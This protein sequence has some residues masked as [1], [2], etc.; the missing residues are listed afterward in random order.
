MPASRVSRFGVRLRALREAANLSQEELADRAGMSVSGLSALERGVRSRP[1]A[2]TLRILREALELDETRWMDLLH[3]AGQTVGVASVEGEQSSTMGVSLTSFV[4]RDEELDWIG[5]L[6]EEHRLVT[7]VGM[8]GIG[9]SRLAGEVL[10]RY[11]S[12]FPGG[13]WGVRLDDLD[14]GAFVVRTVVGALRLREPPDGELEVALEAFLRD[15]RALLVLDGCEP[16]LEACAVLASRLLSACPR[17]AVMATSQASLA[18]PGEALVPLHPLGVPDEAD[19]SPDLRAHA[20]TRLFVERVRLVAPDFDANDEVLPVAELC[21]RLD[22]IPLAIELAAARARLLSPAEIVRR[23]EQG[24]RVLES[25]HM[26]SERHRSLQAALEWSHELLG[27]DEQ[28]LLRRLAVFGGGFTIEAL[29]QVC[30]DGLR[31]DPLLVADELLDRSLVATDRQRRLRLV[32][33]VRRFA[34]DRLVESGEESVIRARHAAAFLEFAEQAEPRMRGPHADEWVQQFELERENLR[35]ALDW[36]VTHGDEGG[37]VRLVAAIAPFWRV[38]GG[39]LPPTLVEIVMRAGAS[40]PGC[41][42]LEGVAFLAGQ[43]GDADTVDR[44]ARRYLD[45]ARALGDDSHV[46]MA[47][48]M[49]QDSELVGL[50]AFDEIVALAYSGNDRWRRAATLCCVQAPDDAHPRHRRCLQEAV[51]EAEAVGDPWL[52][53][54]TSHVFALEELGSGHL[55][56]GRRLLARAAELVDGER[57]PWA[58]FLMLVAL[59]QL[60]LAEQDAGRAVQML[61]AASAIG[62]RTGM[63]LRLASGGEGGELVA[64]ARAEL[65]AN[66]AEAAWRAGTALPYSIALA[67]GLRAQRG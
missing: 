5:H 61:A 36:S 22:G 15:R 41:R 28:M 44:V 47:M 64:R 45:V 8:A 6:L 65:A 43:R 62:E 1:H 38:R 46:A 4:G 67:N 37:V 63:S 53:G 42:A 14:A 54:A 21:R 29:E 16:V 20:A 7:L 10:A 32:D 34:L 23:L 60:A 57:D 48:W 18:L 25:R 49:L 40:A 66:E 17:L 13:A 19:T 58:G 35:S 39:R 3:A 31:A 24:A 26:T 30:C 52:I 55:L 12:R 56:S 27:P 51:A 33:T 50:A 2:H 59:G 9:K 11:G